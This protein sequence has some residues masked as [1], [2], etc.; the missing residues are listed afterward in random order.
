MAHAEGI[1][2]FYRG[3]GSI[4][5]VLPGTM[6]YFASYE[7][8]KQALPPGSGAAGDAAVGVFA[9]LVAGA[10]FTPVDIIKERMQVGHPVRISLKF[11]SRGPLR[12][13]TALRFQCLGMCFKLVLLLVF[14]FSA[15]ADK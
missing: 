9:Q 15:F 2:G 4:L 7:L 14:K 12:G 13:M 11:H 5:G 8:G 10:I 1:L 6:A 3:F